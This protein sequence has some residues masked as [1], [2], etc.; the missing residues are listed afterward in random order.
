MKTAITLTFLFFTY[1]SS[2]QI[3]KSTYDLEP[4]EKYDNIYVKKIDTD[5][6]ST[7]FAIWVKLQVKMHK[8]L[9]HVENV[10]ILEGTGD[11]TVSDSTYEVKKG[12]L[13]VIPKNTWHGLTISSKNPMK[14]ISIQSP[15][16]KGLDRVLKKD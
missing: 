8:H 5:S 13:I 12:D 9:N 6:L 16:F 14:V 7:T 15:E 3:I 2:S 10:Y 4:T 11:F 1:T